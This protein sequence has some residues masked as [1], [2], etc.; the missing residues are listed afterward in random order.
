M[1]TDPTRF[2]VELAGLASRHLERLATRASERGLRPLL[3]EVVHQMI[4]R[5]ETEPRDWCDPYNNYHSLNA[6]GYGRTIVEAGIRVGYAVHDTVPVVWIT[7]V[8]PLVDSP[9]T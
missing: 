7:S 4:E 8:I 3:R 5:L 6:V 1:S 9:F 2:R